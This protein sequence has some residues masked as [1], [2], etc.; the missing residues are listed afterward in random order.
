MTHESATMAD[1]GHDTF[2]YQTVHSALN[3]ALGDKVV[4]SRYLAGGGFV[5]PSTR[6]F[7]YRSYIILS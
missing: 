5:L 6:G 2:V 7:T 3:P 4:E 1:L